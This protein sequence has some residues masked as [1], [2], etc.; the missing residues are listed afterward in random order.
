MRMIKKELYSTPSVEV[1]VLLTE[2]VVCQSLTGGEPGGLGEP[3]ASILPEDIFNGG[4]I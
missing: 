4:I 1:L 3:G 2:G